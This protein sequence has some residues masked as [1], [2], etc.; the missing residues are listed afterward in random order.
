MNHTA[1]AVHS[2]DIDPLSSYDYPSYDSYPTQ[3]TQPYNYPLKLEEYYPQNNPNYLNNGHN[4]TQEEVKSQLT[5]L[6]AKEVKNNEVNDFKPVLTKRKKEKNG[7]K[8]TYCSEK[9]TDAMFPFYGCS[10]CNI[11]YTG[12]HELDQHVTIHK[13][14]MTSYRL[15]LRNQIKKKQIKKEKKKLK[16][17]IKIKKEN[18]LDVDI[19][20]EDGYIG[21]EKATDFINNDNGI[22]SN[23]E[24]N[25]N[26]NN[27]NSA[28]EPI[29]NQMNSN[30]DLNTMNNGSINSEINP[31]TNNGNINNENSSMDN[32][33]NINSK[34]NNM[35]EKEL[36]NLEKIYKCFACQKQFTLSYYLKLH[37]RSHTGKNYHHH[38]HQS[39]VD[40]RKTVL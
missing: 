18:E 20:P 4:S 27:G 34:E 28:I 16:K 5:S 36:N 31:I 40:M 1:G 3:P 9:I 38:H 29:N 25:G 32:G 35:D 39:L 33:N 6:N 2:M 19:K 8:S 14:R 21:N 10:V 26:V 37:V 24:C 22:N 11:S 13:N 12:L 15:R 17:L 7:Q 23:S 30:N